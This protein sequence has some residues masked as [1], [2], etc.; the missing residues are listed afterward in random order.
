MPRLTQDARRAQLVE[1]GLEVFS[2]APY[3]AVSLDDV[4]ARAGISKGL[5]YHYFRTKRD[6]YVTVLQEAAARLIAAVQAASLTGEPAEKLRAGLDAYLDHVDRHAPAYVA[7]LRGGI[8]SDP[9]VARILSATRRAFADR[10]LAELPDPPALLPTALA[11][12]V[13]F[14]EAASLDWVERKL[15][16]AEILRELLVGQLEAAITASFAP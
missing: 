4:A 1:L 3:D 11:G 5:I 15:V 13:G 2:S 8:G 16:P 10:V 14:V 12:W 7:L 6:F 9:E